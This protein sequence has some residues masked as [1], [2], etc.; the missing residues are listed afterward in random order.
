MNA[1]A[2]IPELFFHKFQDPISECLGKITGDQCKWLSSGEL[3]QELLLRIEQLNALSK[4]HQTVAILG[5]TS[6]PWHLCDLALLM[7]GRVVTPIYPTLSPEEIHFILS[8]SEASLLLV[9]DEKLYQKIHS[10]LPGGVEVMSFES[11]VEGIE[12]FG[13]GGE[14]LSAGHA[15][16]YEALKSLCQGIKPQDL[17]SIVYTS[18][19]TGRP[20][21]VMI[22]HE[23]ITTMLSNVQVTFKGRLT[24]EDLNL[25]FLPLSHVLGR[26][27]SLLHLVFPMKTVYSR[28]FNFLTK[29]LLIARPT[30]MISVPRVFEKIYE[31]VF[32][33]LKSM[34]LAKRTAFNFAEK[35]SKRYFKQ[36]RADK[37]PDLSLT[38]LREAAYKAV[39]KNI[40]DQMGG[41]IRFFVSG[42]AP[43]STEV[44]RFFERAGITILEGYGLT[45]TIA[46]CCLNPIRKPIESTVG[47]PLG[48]VEI[49]LSSEQEIMIRSKALFTG[50]WKL[51]E[52][53]KHV[54][55]DGWFYTG[56]IGAWTVEGHLK[57]TDRKKDIIITSGGKNVAPQKI[58]NLLLGNPYLSQALV[59]GDRRKYI[60]A[61]IV[62]NYDAIRKEAERLGLPPGLSAPELIERKEVIS[63]IE[64]FVEEANKELSH[65]E[66]VKSFQL[67]SNE[68]TV[69]NGQ[70]TPSLKAKRKVIEKVYSAE[71]DA[72]YN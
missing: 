1:P 48:D 23:G 38:L 40:Y 19:T 65:F 66:T 26:C 47:V 55:V 56:D 8:D 35:I 29:D 3:C 43:L 31:G 10:H 52:E 62:P 34:S 28:G 16:A 17:A 5:E 39:Y 68:F 9:A 37:I 61:L 53:T 24:E 64:K 69:E 67:L 14:K 4:K 60:S 51:P 30:L 46:P 49:K 22:N 18:G 20:K 21:G 11:N 32:L 44:F 36:Q 27:D 50:Y 70:L 72:M 42:G 57:I 33:K 41:R 12:P 15:Q 58:E 2:T 13:L 6:L 59:I 7:S 54:F 71:I 63:L 45:E 25:V